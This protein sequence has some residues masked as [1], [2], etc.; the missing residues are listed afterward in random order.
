MHLVLT[1]DYKPVIYCYDC[2]LK[3]APLTYITHTAVYDYSVNEL[4][5]TCCGTTAAAEARDIHRLLDYVTLEHTDVCGQYRIYAPEELCA[6]DRTEPYAHIWRI[7]DIYNYC[8][9]KGVLPVAEH[10]LLHDYRQTVWQDINIIYGNL[11]A[12]FV[13]SYDELRN[14]QNWVRIL[15]EEIGEHELIDALAEEVDAALSVLNQ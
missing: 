11:R 5:C 3:N 4:V 9:Y 8:R 13:P 10:K 7:S 12:G 2:F 6:N 14:I 1:A 15:P